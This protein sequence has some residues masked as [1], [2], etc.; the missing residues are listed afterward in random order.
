MTSSITQPSSDSCLKSITAETEAL[1]SC[2]L[3]HGASSRLAD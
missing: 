2:I 3:S 1:G